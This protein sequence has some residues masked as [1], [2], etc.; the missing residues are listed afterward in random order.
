[1]D[2]ETLT[3][4]NRAIAVLGKRIEFSDSFDESLQMLYPTSTGCFDTVEVGLSA[5]GRKK[6]IVSGALLHSSTGE[7]LSFPLLHVGSVFFRTMTG[8][9]I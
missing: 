4:Y 6:I 2:E 8:V 9:I 3:H 5:S 1:M 7:W